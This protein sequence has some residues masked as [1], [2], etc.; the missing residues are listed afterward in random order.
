MDSAEAA[1]TR[2]A[3]AAVR[4]ELRRL[5]DDD[6]SALDVPPEVT[7]RVV[8]ALRRAPTPPDG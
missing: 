6:R 1:H 5:G 2:A 4:R 8:A 3:L 7:D